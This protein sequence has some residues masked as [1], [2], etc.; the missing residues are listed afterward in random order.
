MSDNTEVFGGFEEAPVVTITNQ[1]S[2]DDT[3]V[4]VD[5]T[6]KEADAPGYEWKG[7]DGDKSWLQKFMSPK[8]FDAREIRKLG[9][10]RLGA[11]VLAIVAA[12]VGSLD[13]FT[14]TLV[15]LFNLQALAFA[16]TAYYLFDPSDPITLTG[17]CSRCCCSC[18]CCGPPTSG[19]SCCTNVNWAKTF[20]IQ[21]GTMSIVASFYSISGAANVGDYFSAVVGIL[22]FALTIVLAWALTAPLLDNWE[23]QKAEDKVGGCG[24]C[25]FRLQ[26]GGLYAYCCPC[27]SKWPVTKLFKMSLIIWSSSVTL[28]AI[29]AFASPTGGMD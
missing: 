6:S 12:I 13:S 27:I 19:G 21:S 3:D 24:N 28:T 2:D 8:T 26:T 23:T 25:M 14:K 20:Y 9:Y 10:T 1:P 11:L 15:I 18:E 17:C 22:S 29:I 16:V 7:D 4:T 5:A